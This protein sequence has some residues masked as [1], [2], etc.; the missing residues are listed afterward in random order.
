[1]NV[2]Y[3]NRWYEWYNGSSEFRMTEKWVILEDDQT[4]EAVG[5]FVPIATMAVAF[6][7]AERPWAV[8]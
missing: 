2:M 7:C 6:R 4:K 5:L 1:M 8:A 3:P